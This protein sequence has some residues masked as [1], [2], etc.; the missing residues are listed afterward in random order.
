MAFPN[1]GRARKSASERRKTS[2]KPVSARVETTVHTIMNTLHFSPD[3]LRKISG[4]ILSLTV[5]F[6]AAA[7]GGF[8][9]PGDWYAA[10]EKPSWNPPSWIF[11]P[12][13]TTLYILMAV[14]AWMVWT[15]GGFAAQRRPLCFF[16]AQLLLNAAWT[17]LFFGLHW[18]GIAFA[19]L[20]LL[21]LTLA[22]TL[23][24]FWNVHRPAAWLL[25]PYLLWVGFATLLNGTLWWLNR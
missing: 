16:L 13:W 25:V 20:I 7:L 15:R 12:V 6:S 11:G 14:A 19:E 17:P 9:R 8:F 21:T 22:L 10:L 3:R 4:L 23:R 2:K 5:C 24:A 18:I 1:V